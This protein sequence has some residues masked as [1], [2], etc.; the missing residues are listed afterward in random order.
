MAIGVEI[1]LKQHHTIPS[2]STEVQTQ[3]ERS[4]QKNGKKR[5]H[6]E[7][8]KTGAKD[9][10]QG[11]PSKKLRVQNSS[12]ATGDIALPGASDSPFFVQTTSFYLPLSPIAQATPLE[13]LCAEHLS[14]LILT[15]YHPLKGLVLTYDNARLSDRPN[16]TGGS[17]APVLAKA[18]AEYAVSFT[19]LT[20]DFLLFKAQKGIWIEGYINVQNESHIGLVCYNM[21][22]ASI[23]RRRLPSDWQWVGDKVNKS[24]PRTNGTS[25][26]QRQD[27]GEGYF[28]DNNGNP[29]D[30]LLKF[31]IR[32]FDNTPA[33]GKDKGIMS[34]EGT[35]LDEAE[36][37]IV[38]EEVRENRRSRNSGA[39]GRNTS[40]SQRRPG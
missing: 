38:D 33:M 3:H 8:S 35:L 17:S 16:S 39:R 32:D 29:V 15:Y 37:R 4:S 22:N 2:M 18:I 28:V 12:D 31:C 9:A 36:D 40:V 27:E 25:S 20:A 34:I 5:K 6:T 11:S 13:G 7:R 30:G 1:L 10:D 21:F 14:P 23:D 19:Y 26:F 24:G